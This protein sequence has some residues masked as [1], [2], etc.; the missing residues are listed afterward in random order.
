MAKKKGLLIKFALIFAVFII[1][2][3]AI[4]GVTTFANQTNIYK[5]EQESSIQEVAAYL[6]KILQ[7]DGEE[8]LWYQD[9]FFEHPQDLLIPHDFGPEERDESALRFQR[10]FAEAYP[11]KVLGDD[12][13]FYDMPQELQ[14][15]Y[16]IYS[17]EYYLLLFEQAAQDFNII[18]TYYLVPNTEPNTMF[19]MLD[20]VREDRWI[21]DVNYI[22]VTDSVE[23]VP[24]DHRKMWEA[25]ETGQRPVGYDTYDN[26]Y[27]KTYAYYTP[28]FIGDRKAGVIGVEVEIADVNQ[29][30]LDNTIRQMIW[31]AVVLIVT[32]VITLLY[33]NRRYISKIEHLADNVRE[34]A[35]HKDPD[36][37]GA[38]EKNSGEGQDELAALSNQTAAMILELDNYMRS[39][40]ATTRELTETKEHAEAMH[41]LAHKDALTGIRNKTAYDKEVKKLEWEMSD[42]E[43]R[44]GIA[45]VDLNFLKRINDTYGHEK[46]NI[47]IK[48]LCTMVCTI[49][50]HSP[51][52]R[53]GGDEFVII[54]KD[55]DYDHA[56]EL[57]EKFNNRI[58]EMQQDKALEQ[59]EQ[60][61]AAIGVAFY[62]PEKDD[63]VANVF[64]R[65]DKA[66]YNRKMDMKAVRLV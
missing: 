42:G 6:E 66:M 11:G 59:W 15:A 4:C 40:V 17:H 43:T 44:F 37:A 30:I 28:L 64:K 5:A 49:F 9:Y 22:G 62:D 27:G 63:S 21:G 12:V 38:I 58:E 60:V 25:W 8:F 47:S 50:E 18:Y 1:V 10:M 13:S 39:L 56:D 36:I 55:H 2:T 33:I 14:E 46:G 29:G 53:I 54:L 52:F 61:S 3:L 51:V 26:E 65:A 32:S 34:Y 31:I 19:W 35:Q 16:A 48:K 24:E 41:E 45:M 7:A 20:G 23:E 57:V